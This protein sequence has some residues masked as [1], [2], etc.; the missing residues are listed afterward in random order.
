MNS[1]RWG[2]PKWLYDRGYRNPLLYI[3]LLLA[4]ARQHAESYSPSTDLFF[5]L[6]GS[7]GQETGPI[8]A[9]QSTILQVSI[10]QFVPGIS[11]LNVMIYYSWAHNDCASEASPSSLAKSTAQLP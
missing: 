3:V 4:R 1:A 8:L 10:S 7:P 2:S 5:I 6:E 9:A 11:S